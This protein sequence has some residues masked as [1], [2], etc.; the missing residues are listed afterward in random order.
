MRNVFA[1]AFIVKSF[2]IIF[3][4]FF[5]FFFVSSTFSGWTAK[6][7]VNQCFK[8]SYQKSVG[9]R[10]GSFL[11]HIK[12]YFRKNCSRSC[13]LRRVLHMTRLLH[14]NQHPQHPKKHKKQS[15]TR[16]NFLACQQM[17]EDPRVNTERNQVDKQESLKKKKRK[18]VQSK[19][20][21]AA[22]CEAI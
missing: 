14:G 9:P 11:G 22:P 5:S 1:F 13:Y 7:L 17:A 3:L 16:K 2:A 20:W 4:V 8:I 6:T 10:S 19:K 15:E 18:D 21:I 12:K